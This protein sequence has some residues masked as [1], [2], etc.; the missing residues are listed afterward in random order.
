MVCE[1]IPIPDDGE[2]SQSKTAKREPQQLSFRLCRKA[3]PF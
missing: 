1:R 2:E 3:E